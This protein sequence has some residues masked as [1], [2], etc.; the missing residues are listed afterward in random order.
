MLMG[1]GLL[2]VNLRVSTLGDTIATLK[3]TVQQQQT[4]IANLC[5]KAG[6]NICLAPKK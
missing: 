5:R 4:Q 3:T 2:I 1:A 6:N